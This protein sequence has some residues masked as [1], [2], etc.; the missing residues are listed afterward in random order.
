MKKRETFNP[1]SPGRPSFYLLSI[2]AII[3]AVALLIGLN[4]STAFGAS[5]LSTTIKEDIPYLIDLY[6]HLHSHPELSLQEKETSN[7]IAE[8]L[9]KA[10]FS[11]TRGVGGY[12]VVG[13]LEN[14]RGPT[15]MLRTDMDALPVQEETGLVYASQVKALDADG[16][17][18]YVMHACGH[19]VHMTT[20]IGA[21]R[22]LS[23]VKE[24]WRGT[25]LMV[26]QPAEEI[27]SGAQA[28][29]DDGLFTRF[30]RPDYMIGIHAM[31]MP[32]GIIGYREGYIFAGEAIMHIKV[33]GIGGHGAR[34]HETKD[35]IVM[36][37]QMILDFQ[38]IVSREVDPVEPAVVTVGSIHGGMT[39]NVIAEEVILKLTLRAYP[40]DLRRN[41]I[42]SVKRKALAVAM[43]NNVP[44]DR[45]PEVMVISDSPAVYND[46]KL[47]KRLIKA[48]S[49]KL[50]RYELSKVASSEDFAYYGLVEP[51][52]PSAFFGLGVYS[53]KTI[54]E[55]QEKGQPLPGPHS[56]RFA[57]DDPER[58][59]KTGVKALG[60][61]VLDLLKKTE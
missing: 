39:D 34:P 49:R 17:E 18:T 51:K 1:N 22:L 25:L 38:T 15:V 14:G 23:R 37:A 57:S 48:I 8:E 10:G 33:K 52:I 16:K 26:A 44:E 4:T 9:E 46:P 7:R 58:T 29:I 30:P 36:A 59:F 53:M 13:V 19:D 42:E 27:M 43:A 40:D 32:V 56:P 54:N 50:G 35:P 31:P 41:M 21:A 12:G 60:L 47:T 24:D 55:F 45:F 11:V 6:K 2:N 5:R 28:M 61:F 20:F 3:F